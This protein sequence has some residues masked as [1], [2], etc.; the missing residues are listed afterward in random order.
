MPKSDEL[1]QKGDNVRV[2]DLVPGDIVRLPMDD[3][4]AVFLTQCPHPIWDNVQLVIWRM[5]NP[6]VGRG[7]WSHDAL[8]LDQVV[9]NTDSTSELRRHKAL[10]WAL[11]K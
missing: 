2:R 11:G 10:L 4:S 1:I 7:N 3:L 8:S 5:G 6:S 9:G